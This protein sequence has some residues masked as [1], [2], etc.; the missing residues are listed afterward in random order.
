[1]IYYPLST[2]IHAGVTEVLLVSSPN[3]LDRFVSL[4]KDGSQYG[5][6]I[7]YQEQLIPAGLPQGIT[8]A[9]DFL[10]GESFWFVLGDNLFHGPDFGASLREFALENEDGAG[11]FAYRVSDVSQYGV[12]TFSSD[13]EK[14]ATVE[15][16]PSRRVSGWAIPGLYFFDNQAVDSARRLAIS[17][18]GEYEIIDLIKNYQSVGKL[19]VKRISRGNAWFDLG[20]TENLLTG[21]NFVH[22][23]QTRQGQL[24]GSPEEAALNAGILSPQ[25]FNSNIANSPDSSYFQNLRQLGKINFQ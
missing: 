7:E 11:V 4:L 6:R 16:K 24:V 15:E 13:G 1:M 9:A 2:L 10:S 25:S 20:T 8:L 14:V 18:R 22:L 3:Q 21:S 12:V 17:P 19:T 23:I 5:I